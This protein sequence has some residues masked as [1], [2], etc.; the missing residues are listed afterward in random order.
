VELQKF[1]QM[2]Q[3]NTRHSRTSKSSS[4][5]SNNKHGHWQGEVGM[6][7]QSLLGG[8]AGVLPGGEPESSRARSG[9]MKVSAANSGLP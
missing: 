7:G 8:Q 9:V 3:C 1:K 6:G 4:G 2:Q 5:G